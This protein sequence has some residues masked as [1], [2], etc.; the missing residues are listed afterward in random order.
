MS[1]CT[2]TNEEVDDNVLG[3]GVTTWPWWHSVDESPDGKGYVAVIEDPDN[4][5]DTIT[6]EF[7]R[8]AV[9]TQVTKIMMGQSSAN[10]RIVGYLR[11]DDPDA[12]A[13]DCVLQLVVFGEIVYG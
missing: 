11:D 8:S 2:W 9:R 5:E 13:M 3:S 6:F 12:D 1:I 10:D 7:S 4:C